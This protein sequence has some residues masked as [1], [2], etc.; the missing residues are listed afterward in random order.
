MDRIRVKIKV[1]VYQ[2]VNWMQ[3]YQEEEDSLGSSEVCRA[4][5]LRVNILPN[6]DIHIDVDV[7]VYQWFDTMQVE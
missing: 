1:D 6:K 4:N 5:S 3:V 7:D 2:G